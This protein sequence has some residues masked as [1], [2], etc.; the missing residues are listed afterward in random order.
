MPASPV[1]RRHASADVAS[2]KVLYIVSNAADLKGFPVGFF[3]EELTGPFFDLM[4]AGCTVDIASPQ[5]GKP[6]S[7][8]S[9][10]PNTRCHN[11]PTI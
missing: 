4:Q 8:Q 9:P 11:I 2:K 7:T 5:G 3:A 6:P 1:I 10:T